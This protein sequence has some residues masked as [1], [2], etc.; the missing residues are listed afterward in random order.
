MMILHG[1]PSS[2]R[3]KVRGDAWENTKDLSWDFP[4]SPVVKTLPLQ[5][6]QV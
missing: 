6:V 3:N 1:G 5:G 4:G 2:G